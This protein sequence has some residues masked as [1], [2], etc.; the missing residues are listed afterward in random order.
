MSD[1]EDLDVDADVSDAEAPKGQWD[2][3]DAEEEEPAPEVAEPA[4]P[5]ESTMKKPK[6]QKQLLE[7]KLRE[8]EA[9][10]SERAV[11]R[12]AAQDK[13]LDGLS[14]VERKLRL[15]KMVEDADFENSKELFMDGRGEAVEREEP[16][17][18]GY[19]PK[20]EDDHAAFGEIVGNKLQGLRN[21]RRPYPHKL[22]MEKMLRIA[23]ND[24]TAEDIKDLAGQLNVV[25]NEKLKAKIDKNKKGKKGAA[26]RHIK[27][28]KEDDESSYNR[29]EEY[30]DFM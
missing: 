15:Q 11:A 14:E 26:K 2:D 7:E 30:D 5:L 9:K 21:H 4:K 18:D 22:M 10:E 3:E 25:A 19:T 24:M 8:R 17:L 13:E 23:V 16:K 29:F 20:T 12:A 28:D 6:K 27:V 1:W